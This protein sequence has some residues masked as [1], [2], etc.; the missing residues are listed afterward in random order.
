MR[1]NVNFLCD[2]TCRSIPLSLSVSSLSLLKSTSGVNI[3]GLDSPLTVGKPATI[4]CTTNE[5]VSSIEW[6][7]ESN[8][9]KITT[10]TNVT[11]LNYT[12][13]PVTDDM[14]GQMYV[15]KAV[16]INV[17]DTDSVELSV[18]GK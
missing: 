5:P 16:S 18:E 12:I 7:N 1:F 10:T 8:R 3:T 4:T 11:V 2:Y 15:C 13:S 6:I 17:T 14:Q 9:L